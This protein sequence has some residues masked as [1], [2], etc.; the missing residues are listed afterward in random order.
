L[1]CARATPPTA[2]PARVAWHWPVMALA[3]HLPPHC[4]AGPGCCAALR[5]AAHMRGLSDSRRAGTSSWRRR[6][7]ETKRTIS[8]ALKPRQ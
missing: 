2:A 5:R 7:A 3:R 8:G 6:A 4:D 1:P